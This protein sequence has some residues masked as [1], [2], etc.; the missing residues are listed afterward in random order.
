MRIIMAPPGSNTRTPGLEYVAAVTPVTAVVGCHNGEPHMPPLTLPTTAEALH[1][2]LTARTAHVG[3]VGLGYV[4]LPLAVEMAR[5]GF[6]TTGIDLA[7]RKVETIM[8][9]ESYI[10]TVHTR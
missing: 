5:A 2:K 8:R 7:P 1:Q 3:I 10:P 9:G 4:G 6:K